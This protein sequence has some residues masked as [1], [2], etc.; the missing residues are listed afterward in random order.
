MRAEKVSRGAM[1]RMGSKP[2]SEMGGSVRGEVQRRM[3]D[4]RRGSRKAIWETELWV[5]WSE[6]E[7]DASFVGS[8]GSERCNTN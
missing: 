5:G 1:L 4:R 6:V 7:L 8:W 3:R 2:S